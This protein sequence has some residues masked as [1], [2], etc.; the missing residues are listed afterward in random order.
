MFLTEQLTV[1]FQVAGA[2]TDLATSTKLKAGSWNHIALTLVGGT[3]PTVELFV[4]GEASASGPTE[5]PANAK[6]GIIE[7]LVRQPADE[8]QQYQGALDEIRVWSYPLQP[9]TIKSR[10]FTRLTGMEPYLEAC[11]HLDEASGLMAFDATMNKYDMLIQMTSS[12]GKQT[13]E[14][15]SPSKVDPPVLSVWNERPAKMAASTGLSKRQIRLPEDVAID[16][17][18]G[19]SVYYEQVSLVAPTASSISAS[20]ETADEQE[21]KEK[22]A[23]AGAKPLKRGA[24]LLLCF[25]AKVKS[26]QKSTLAIIDFGLLSDGTLCDSPPVVPLRP[27]KAINRKAD[28]AAQNKSA[29]KYAPTSLLYID[30]AGIEIFGG[31][32]DF[33]AA[34]CSAD[35][36]YVWDSAMGS[37]TI[38]YKN[39][40]D[41]DPGGFSALTYDVSRSMDADSLVALVKFPGVLA[42]SKLRQA[43]N[44]TIKTLSS[45]VDAEVAVNVRIAATTADGEMSELWQ[46][47]YVK[48]FRDTS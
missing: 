36:P 38:Y 8:K 14:N 39:M 30:P 29:E 11:W 12:L 42:A 1:A 17:G 27:I 7:Q 26:K 18:L 24:R 5:L 32:L 31:Y 6:P 45:G 16:G 43:K 15:G 46:C 10:M 33:P 28:A 13:P 35:T 25:V 22:K 41:R 2:A 9:A 37:V 19:A 40:A 47:R 23:K 20:K 4:N 34:Q 48:S 3:A 44:V 21:S